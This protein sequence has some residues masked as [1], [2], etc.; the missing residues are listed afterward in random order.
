[1]SPQAPLCS[2]WHSCS[3]PG[4]H[5]RSLHA[6]PAL[7]PNWT[8]SLAYARVEDRIASCHQVVLVVFRGQ[9]EVVRACVRGVQWGGR[10]LIR[11]GQS[12]ERI[13][14]SF[15]ILPYPANSRAWLCG[16]SP[17][18]AH[19][20]LLQRKQYYYTTY[21]RPSH[22]SSSPYRSPYRSPYLSPSPSPFRI[23]RPQFH[24]P[25]WSRWSRVCLSSTLSPY[26]EN[27]PQTPIL[28]CLGPIPLNVSEEVFQHIKLP[29][30]KVSE[31]RGTDPDVFPRWDRVVPPRTC[32][33]V[34][35]LQRAYPRVIFTLNIQLT[36]SSLA[37][38]LEHGHGI[39]RLLALCSLRSSVSCLIHA[40]SATTALRVRR[41]R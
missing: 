13:R 21:S 2:T 3:R 5:K 18:V 4:A 29:L 9:R 28:T 17:L 34:R 16:H 23:S 37:L 35:R 20:R 15:K 14:F 40:P 36:S 25:L 11:T 38:R 24:R 33:I 12:R 1:M 19:S 26:A 7:G 8:R 31:E 10:G 6:P 39:G 30:R 41:R 27:T 32:V 22:R